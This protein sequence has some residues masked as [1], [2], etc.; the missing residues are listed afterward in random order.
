MQL[1]FCYTFEEIN[2]EVFCAYTVPYTY[3]A[4]LA[5]LK[6]LKLLS[7]GIAKHTNLG[8]SLG[9]INIPLLKISNNF[10][11]LKPIIVIIG[12]QHPGETHSSFII[13]GFINHIMSTNP[14]ANKFRDFFETWILPVVNPDGVVCGNYRSNLQGK[15][16]NRCF[17]ADGDQLAKS[18]CYEVELL[19]EKLKQT[20]KARKFKMFLD[21]HSHSS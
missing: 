6:Q 12:R 7:T 19:R 8:S 16:M 9:G 13:H 11:D 10:C 21:I 3:S 5:H 4:V 2:D 18:R 15:D 1:S 14:L 17:Y 20:F